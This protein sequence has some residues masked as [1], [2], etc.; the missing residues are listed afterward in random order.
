M[1]FDD[2]LVQALLAIYQVKEL[3]VVYQVEASNINVGSV[4]FLLKHWQYKRSQYER[5][6]NLKVSEKYYYISVE[7]F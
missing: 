4:H 1:Q 2:K 7:I 5:R 6:K 3:S